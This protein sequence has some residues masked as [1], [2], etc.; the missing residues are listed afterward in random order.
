MNMIGVTRRN[1]FTTSNK[2]NSERGR[3]TDGE[4]MRIGVRSLTAD[5]GSWTAAKHNQHTEP[6]KKRIDDSQ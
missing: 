6:I 2:R 5:G 1:N 3:E 4:G